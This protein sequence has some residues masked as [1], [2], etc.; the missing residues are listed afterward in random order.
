[1]RILL[2]GANGYIGKRLLP[3]LLSNGHE[4]IAVVRDKR[5]FEHKK[6]NSSL[7]SVI[8][9]DFLNENLFKTH[10]HHPSMLLII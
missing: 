2:T 9:V 8:E 10:Y 4:V 7:L 6:Y 1:M 5:R 3:L